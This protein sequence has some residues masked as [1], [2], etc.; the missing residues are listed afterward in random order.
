MGIL[1]VSESTASKTNQVQFGLRVGLL[2]SVCGV[3]G[4]SSVSSVSGVRLWLFSFVF[5]RDSRRSAKRKTE[6]F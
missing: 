6:N 1:A 2:G 5:S 4:V 3:C